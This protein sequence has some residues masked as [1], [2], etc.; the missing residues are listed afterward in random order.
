MRARRTNIATMDIR[1]S[2]SVSP[3]PLVSPSP[4]P[5]PALASQPEPAPQTMA[6]PLSPEAIYS[7]R[8]ELYTSIQAWAAQHYFVFRIERSKKINKGVR[9][10]ILY[11]CD[12]AGLA[13]P[14]NHPQ[15]SLQDRKRCTAT[16]KTGCQFSIVALECTDIQWELRHRPG[17][18]YSI[19]NHPPSQSTS[20]YLAHRKLAQAEINQA[21]SLHNVGKSKYYALK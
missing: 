14:A 3:S 7:S 2:I 5:Q 1:L 12:R 17:T 13:P 19:H 16:R 11:S 9:T 20:S 15:R 4:E 21:R 6:M 8:E 18:E 10:K